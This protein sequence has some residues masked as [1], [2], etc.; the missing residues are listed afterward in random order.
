MSDDQ[1]ESIIE[2]QHDEIDSHLPD[3]SECE[4]RHCEVDDGVVVGLLTPRQGRRTFVVSR[5][6]AMGEIIHMWDNEIAYE[7]F[8]VYVTQY[9][10]WAKPEFG[11]VS[12]ALSEFFAWCD[13]EVPALVH[14]ARWLRI[15]HEADTG[16]FAYDAD[17][18]LV[19][20]EAMIAD[21][22]EV[23]DM[24]VAEMRRA[25]RGEPIGARDPAQLGLF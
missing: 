22:A 5:R 15:D 2:A 10:S 16:I 24:P 1:F 12:P 4:V 14:W 23:H 18:A 19:I 9:A 20:V 13:P 3:L 25:V 11:A 6:E 21:M 8:A 17:L 7:L